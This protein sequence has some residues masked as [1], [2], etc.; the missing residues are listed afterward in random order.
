MNTD[1]TRS[2]CGQ[3]EQQTQIDAHLSE[4]QPKRMFARFTNVA[5]YYEIEKKVTS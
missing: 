5:K 4:I 3:T 2:Y 1:P